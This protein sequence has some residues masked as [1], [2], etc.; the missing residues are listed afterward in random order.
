ML[1][2]WRPIPLLNILYKIISIMLAHKIKKVI[3]KII[4]K[5]QKVFVDIRNLLDARRGL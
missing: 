5:K 1:G 3:P 2:N 4:G